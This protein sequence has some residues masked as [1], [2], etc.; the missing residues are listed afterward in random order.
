M[1]TFTEDI[2][3]MSLTRLGTTVRMTI[4]VM[5]RGKETWP[6]NIKQ[7]VLIFITRHTLVAEKEGRIYILWTQNHTFGNNSES[8]VS[9]LDDR[10]FESRQGLGISLFTTASRPALGATQPP[11]EWVLGALS[12]RVKRTTHLHLVPRSRMRGAIPP[13]H[14]P[15]R[16]RS[17]VLS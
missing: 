17:E 16:L 14:S 5:K 13:L 11:I 7:K 1:L 2:R 4:N 3:G 15:I 8:H 9:G 6:D 10:G 12:L